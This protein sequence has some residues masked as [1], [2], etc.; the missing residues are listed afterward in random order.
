MTE[1]LVDVLGDH[2]TVL[3]TLPVT[4]S[5][6]NLASSDAPF[7]TKALEAAA[8]G[9]LVPHAELNH[10]TS[11]MHV[12]RGG[13]LEPFGADRPVTLQTP[14]SVDQATRELAYLLW[15]QDGSP[16]GCAEEYWHRARE[17][18]LRE[19]AYALWHLEGC[20]EG[21][22]DDHWRRT[23]TFDLYDR[24]RADLIQRMERPLGR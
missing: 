13:P 24:T 21:G 7:E 8:L 5:D 16:P 12:S 19:G 15:Q 11:R 20:P 22:A 10:L 2:H 18:Q 17:Q 4:I 9:H 23:E 3:H 14:E 6:P 1:R